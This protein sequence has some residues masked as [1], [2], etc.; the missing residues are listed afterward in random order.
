MKNLLF[1]ILSVY[2]IFSSCTAPIEINTK[3]SDPVPI[4]YGY[5]TDQNIKQY[6]RILSSSPYFEE[7]KESAIDNADVSIADAEGE[8]YIFNYTEDGYYE[9]VLAFAAKEN[10]KYHLTVELDFDKDGKTEFYEA[11]TTIPEKVM[12]DSIVINPLT[13]MG[14]RHFALNLYLQEPAETKNFYLCK[15][16]INDTI[17]NGKMDEY[18]IFEDRMINGTYLNGVTINYFEDAT[19][20]KNMQ[21]Y[22][23]DNRNQYLVSPGD[24]IILQVINIE[25]G[26]YHFINEC[27][28]EKNGENPFFG[29]PPSNIT[30][31]ISNGAIGYFSGYAIQ[32]LE[33]VIP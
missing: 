19:D 12:A 10:M 8:N 4:I 6:I 15:F 26:Y 29:G 30:T 24:K 13:L 16:T 14:F 3:N 27:V 25:E 7:I 17:S 18:I 1:H 21:R 28:R 9:S 23:D 33:S 2:F 32:E 31:N 5:I 11:E 20:E 22:D